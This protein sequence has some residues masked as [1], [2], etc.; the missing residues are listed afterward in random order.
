[1]TAEGATDDAEPMNRFP[2]RSMS[3]DRIREVM[4]QFARA[5]CARTAGLDGVELAGANGMLFTQF[6]SPSINTRK[7]DYGGSLENRARLLVETLRAVR[8]AVGD[9]FHVQV[10]ISATE[11]ADAF[12][13]WLR[14]GNTIRGS[15]HVCRWLEEARADAIHVSAGSTF[16]HPLNPAGGLPLREVRDNYDGL[17][18]S[19][20]HAF[21]NY[22]LYRTPLVNRIM[23]RR[24]ERP[25]K[26]VEGANLDDA[27]GDQGSGV[28]PS[29]LHR[30]VPD[31]VGRARGVGVGCMRRRH[32]RAPARRQ[33]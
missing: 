24:W 25:A 23:Q 2:C 6:L 18:S 14:G 7:D 3:V 33:S 29:P 5:A 22:L 28:H 26:S 19:G 11:R 1:M 4:D 16:P 31:R 10:K 27:T 17:V 20:I 30:R 15:A 12:L 8:Q 32:D 9:D 21:R 13:P